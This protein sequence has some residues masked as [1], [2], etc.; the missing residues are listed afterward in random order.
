M[1]HIALNFGVVRFMA[2]K[3][4]RIENGILGIKM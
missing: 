1:L 4:L 2:D 3:T